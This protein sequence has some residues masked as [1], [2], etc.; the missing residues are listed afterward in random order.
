M[1]TTSARSPNWSTASF[2]Q[3]PDTTPQE[4]GAL[5]EH[6]NLCRGRHGRWSVLSGPLQALRGAIAARA[7]TSWL[8]AG[9]LLAI[10]IAVV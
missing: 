1:N 2:G 3:A 6:L 10:G 4:L 5:G 7:M 9:L 8:V